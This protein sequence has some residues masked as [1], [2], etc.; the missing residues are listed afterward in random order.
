MPCALL[1]CVASG[2]FCSPSQASELVIGRSA[3][4]A[5][6][7]S[8]LFKD[9]GRLY[10]TKGKCYA[11]LERPK[12]SLAS[13]RLVMDA[14]LSSHVGV[15]VGDSCLG[16]GLASDVQLTGKFVGYGSQ[17]TLKDIK[18]DNVKDDATRQALDLLQSAAGASLPRA[19]DIDLMQVL[20][21][22]L[23]PGTDIKASVAAISIAGVTTN[24]ESVTVSFDIKL[25]AD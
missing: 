11:Y 23:F 22:A 3:V 16:T 5:I 19:V 7:V 2:V 25:H 12:I 24:P 10:L 14:H 20:K 18:I 1:L 13:G 4:Q 9:Q 6:V 21:P 17:L 8:A 15:E